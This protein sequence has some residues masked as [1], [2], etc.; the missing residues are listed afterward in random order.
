MGGCG[1][2][3]LHDPLIRPVRVGML[4]RAAC[5]IPRTTLH[6]QSP[7]RPRDAV[8]LEGVSKAHFTRRP[9]ISPGKGQVRLEV[10]MSALYTMADERVSP[11]APALRE[12]RGNNE[13]SYSDGPRQGRPQQGPRDRGALKSTEEQN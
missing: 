7:D 3:P 4:F 6:P 8:K 12:A 10:L 11:W 9:R 2:G 1:G 5:S 13:P